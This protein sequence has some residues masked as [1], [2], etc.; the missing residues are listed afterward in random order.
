[1]SFLARSIVTL[2]AASFVAS[3]GSSDDGGSGGVCGEDPTPPGAT[4]CPSECTGGCQDGVCTIDCTGF[5]ACDTATIACPADHACRI[6]CDGGDACDSST[7]ECAA[8]FA[9]EIDCDG[10]VDACGDLEINCN[11]AST[12]NLACSDVA[13]VCT[14]AFL[15]CGSG[16]C[17]ASCAGGSLPMVECGDSCD[18]TQC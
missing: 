7:I 10:G 14:G 1:M 3:C 13:M 17:A 12:C 11:A 5:G 2:V 16:A 8:G 15:A 18:C 6:V 4:A 9:C